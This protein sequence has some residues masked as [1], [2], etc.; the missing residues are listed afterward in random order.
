MDISFISRTLKTTGV[1][2]LIVLTF[3]WMYLD[4]YHVLAIFSGMIWSMINLYFLTLLV[5]STIRPEGVDKWAAFGFLFIKFPLLYLAGYFLLIV[6][7]FELKYLLIGFTSIF[8]V[9]LLK[10]LGRVVLGL[11]YNKTN[12]N[13]ESR[14]TV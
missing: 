3:G 10:V 12:I 13:A 7:Y 14:E 2:G 4:I 1:L 6:P 9:M 8:A 11:D 5:R